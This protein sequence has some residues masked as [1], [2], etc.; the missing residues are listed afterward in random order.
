MRD[1]EVTASYSQFELLSPRIRGGIWV[2]NGHAD[3]ERKSDVGDHSR[4]ME[5]LVSVYSSVSASFVI[6]VHLGSLFRPSSQ[7]PPTI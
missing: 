1:H 3:E 5:F 4:R 7:G 6:S 2:G